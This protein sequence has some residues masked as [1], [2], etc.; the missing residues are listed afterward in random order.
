MTLMEHVWTPKFQHHYPCLNSGHLASKASALTT[1]LPCITFEEKCLSEGLG[2]G[3]PT[4]FLQDRFMGKINA[5]TANLAL[6][7]LLLEEEDQG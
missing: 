7:L 4:S 2:L 1:E 6:L 3:V 5:D